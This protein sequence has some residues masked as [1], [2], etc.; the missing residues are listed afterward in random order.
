ML[1][2]PGAGGGWLLKTTTKLGGSVEFGGNIKFCNPQPPPPPPSLHNPSELDFSNLL[3]VANPLTSLPPPR[4]PL[5]WV[6]NVNLAPLTFVCIPQDYYVLHRSSECKSLFNTS[7][8][9][10]G[11]GMTPYRVG[12]PPIH[13]TPPHTFEA[14]QLRDSS[15]C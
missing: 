5:G 7:K 4:N 13:V 1:S 9:R 15:W 11:D 10:L 8:Q 14:L 6:L 3:F 2:T 12:C